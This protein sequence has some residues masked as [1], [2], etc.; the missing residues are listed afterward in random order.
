M[1]GRGWR[2]VVW[3]V[4]F[5][6]AVALWHAPGTVI[7]SAFGIA[8]TDE[9]VHAAASRASLLVLW[10]S[11][12]LGLAA[13]AQ[14][15]TFARFVHWFAAG[16]ALRMRAQCMP[17]RIWPLRARIEALAGLVA[18]ALVLAREAA[19]LRWLRWA[20]APLAVQ[21]TPMRARL[22][23][24]MALLAAFVGAVVHG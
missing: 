20:Q 21:H 22:V 17:W 2:P 9:G 5:S 14:A 23:G 16:R 3:L 18:L 10:W 4:L 6:S 8:I 11:V 7:V 19:R 12:G 24:G 15:Q 13:C 1:S